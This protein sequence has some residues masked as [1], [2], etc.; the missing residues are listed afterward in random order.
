MNA[1]VDGEPDLCSFVTIPFFH[2]EEE[3]SSVQSR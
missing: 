1:V 3:S 2:Q